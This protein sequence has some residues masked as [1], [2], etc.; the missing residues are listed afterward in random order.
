MTKKIYKILTIVIVVAMLLSLVACGSSNSPSTNNTQVGENETGENN[1]GEEPTVAPGKKGT[2]EYWT[3]FTGA[4]GSSMQ[5]IVDAYNETDPDYTVNHRP[6]EANDLYQKLPIA[7]NSGQDVPDVAIVHVERIPS[8]VEN[9]FLTD[10]NELIGSSEI[11]PENYNPKAWSM[12]EIDG[13]HYGIPLDVHSYILYV[14]MDL[15][16]KYGKGELD[17][18]VLTWDEVMAVD[19]AVVNDGIIPIGMGWLRVK[20]LAAYAQLGG[21]L[22]SDGE[23]PDFNN[24]TAI[25]VLELWQKLSDAGLTQKEG[26]APW[27]LFL[28][29]KVLYMPEGIWMLNDVK[30]AGLNYAM[31]DYPVFDPAQKGNWTS[32]H[33][34]VIPKD[35][36]RDEDRVNAV[37]DF[38]NYVGNNSLEWAKAGQVPAHVSIKDVEEFQNM[39]QRFLADQDD[40]LK[41]YN[42]KYYGFAVEALDKVLGDIFFGRLT[43]QEGLDKAVQETK[44]RIAVGG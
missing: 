40:E 31:Y 27:E 5:A 42:Y 14:N 38:I 29:G 16:E 8:F 4:D 36:K 11:K 41:I 20:F 3:V 39:P 2:L 6:I 26:D 32:S 43:P 44:D 10:L 34:F 35:D 25:K 18:G 23:N 12:T 13:G 19:E 22:S 28:G 7:I 17:D 33:N 30:E 37:L 9:G 15:Y 21:T 24:E 1:A